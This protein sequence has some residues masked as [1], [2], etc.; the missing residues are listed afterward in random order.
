MLYGLILT[1]LVIDG[2]LLVDEDFPGIAA[3]S[4]TLRAYPEPFKVNAAHIL[5][6]L[7]ARYGAQGVEL[8]FNDALAGQEWRSAF[9][10]RRRGRPGFGPRD[11]G[12]SDRP[13]TRRAGA[14]RSGRSG[15]RRREWKRP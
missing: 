12:H 1:L 3:D 4:Q 9:L 14:A 6:Y 11:A 8:A 13:S 10:S 2:L 5:G 7:S 15:R